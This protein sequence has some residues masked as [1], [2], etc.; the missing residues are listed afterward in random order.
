VIAVGLLVAGR[1]R[2]ATMPYGPGL[3]LGGLAALFFC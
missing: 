1:S 2:H 3:C